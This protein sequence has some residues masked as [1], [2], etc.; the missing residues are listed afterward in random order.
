MISIFDEV[1][2]I[3]GKVENAGYHAVKS[4]LCGSDQNRGLFGGFSQDSFPFF[5]R[6]CC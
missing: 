1:E 5:L 2:D 6:P 3:V 4:L